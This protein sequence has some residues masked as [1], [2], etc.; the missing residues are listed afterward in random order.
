MLP[1]SSTQ[2]TTGLQLMVPLAIAN[3]EDRGHSRG[4]LSP[5]PGFGQSFRSHCSSSYLP[6]SG[7]CS[8]AC[9]SP[10]VWGGEGKH[11]RQ[12]RRLEE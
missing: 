6:W 3:L 5:P 8:V 12:D 4:G 2:W 1:C 11:G 7:C 9:V 10:T